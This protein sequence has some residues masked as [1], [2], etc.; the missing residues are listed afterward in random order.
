MDGLARFDR[1]GIH[2]RYPSNW[3]L[4]V[5]EDASSGG[6]TATL[7]SPQTAFALIA[8]RPEADN[9]DQLADEVLAAL[10]SEYRELDA[11][12]RVETVAGQMAV[13]H[14]IDFLTLDTLSICR[15][16]ALETPAGPLLILRQVSEYDRVQNE[17]VL[18]AIVA[19]LT[20]DED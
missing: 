12:D 1:D 13:G 20:V 16:R 15:T 11:E 2:F 5:D 8:L 10:R 4:E 6:W 3:K 9:I 14:D 17:P 7:T 18:D 19:S